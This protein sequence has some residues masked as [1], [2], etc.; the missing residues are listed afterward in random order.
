M[1]EKMKMWLLLIMGIGFLFAAASADT[2][3]RYKSVAEVTKSMV[4]DA[5]VIYNISGD[6]N[7]IETTTKFSMK[8]IPGNPFNI[9]S[10]NI[11][12]L[13]KGLRWSLFSGSTY[14]EETLITIHSSLKQITGYAWTFESALM[15]DKK[16][17]NKFQCIGAKGKAVGVSSSDPADTVFITMEQWSAEDTSMAAE[18]LA[19]QNSYQRVAETNR[20]WAQEHLSTFLENGYGDQFGKLFD[21]MNTERTIPIQTTFKIERTVLYDDTQNSSGGKD[22]KIGQKPEGVGYWPLLI[23]TNELME[24]KNKK[25]AAD[26]FEVPADFKLK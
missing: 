24:I 13:D 22:N 10:Q 17:I 23:M 4:Y 5:K 12:R 25:I 20:L 1:E 7:Y 16:K 26:K 9:I 2:I 8:N 3:V 15:D 19:Y 6:K 11:T 21:M 14:S 18:L